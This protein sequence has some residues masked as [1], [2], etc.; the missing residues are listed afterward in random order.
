MLH[1]ELPFFFFFVCNDSAEP[2]YSTTIYALY[3]LQSKI[4]IP[5]TDPFFFS[6]S[7]H[8]TANHFKTCSYVI[9]FLSSHCLLYCYIIMPYAWSIGSPVTVAVAVAVAVAW[10]YEYERL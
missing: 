6:Y 8:I 7:R 1:V 5:K 9:I 4:C 3:M 2:T 10:A